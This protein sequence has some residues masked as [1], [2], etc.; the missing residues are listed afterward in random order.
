MTTRPP[1]LEGLGAR[2]GSEC[3]LCLEWCLLPEKI[4]LCCVMF[5]KLFP[6]VP[7]L[8]SDPVV[9]EKCRHSW[10]RPMGQFSELPFGCL[11]G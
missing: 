7:W 8:P 4:L 2:G 6:S 11:G 5:Q 9:G 3:P 10:L 1:C